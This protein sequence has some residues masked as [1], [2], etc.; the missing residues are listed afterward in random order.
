MRSKALNIDMDDKPAKK[1]WKPPFHDWPRPTAKRTRWERFLRRFWLFRWDDHRFSFA[2]TGIDWCQSQCYRDKKVARYFPI[3]NWIREELPRKRLPFKWKW[4]R[5]YWGIRHRLPGRYWHHTLDLGLKPG[6]YD[7]DTKM[8]HAT[9]E[10]VRW[11]VEVQLAKHQDYERKKYPWHNGRSPEAGLA[12]LDWE[13]EECSGPPGSPMGQGESAQ[14]KKDVYLWWTVDRPNRIDP[15]DVYDI[16][17][18][19]RK[20]HAERKEEKGMWGLFNDNSDKRGMWGSMALEDFYKKED[21][22]MLSKA[23]SILHFWWD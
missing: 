4:D 9:F 22:E 14:I 17:D 19:R 8:L 18:P 2:A 1:K 5:L 21:Q 11:F 20:S 6:Y 12:H 13:I 7:A 23:V 16:A 10:I 3:R 15:H